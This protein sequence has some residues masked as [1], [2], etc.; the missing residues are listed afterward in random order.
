MVHRSC[1][2]LAAYCLA[3][4]AVLPTLAF[5]AGPEVTLERIMAHPDWIGNPPEEPFWGDDGRSVY[6]VRKRQGEERRDLYRVDLGTNETT[7]V[8]D[9]DRGAVDARGGE[10]SRD[11]RW[12][13]YERRGDVY[14]KNLETGELR[15]I[16]RTAAREEDPR[17]LVGASRISYRQDNGFFIV[18]LVSGLVSQAADLRL[19]DDPAG[20]KG[21][22][23]LEG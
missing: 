9:E 5:A 22:A 1:R 11:R 7:I 8:A 6:F 4:L 15:Q 20:E 3:V 21:E 14:L 2:R 23:W 18:D 13:V 17:F 16:T 10:I 19:E 12:K